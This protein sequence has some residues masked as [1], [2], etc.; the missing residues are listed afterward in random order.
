VLGFVLGSRAARDAQA[1]EQRRAVDREARRAARAAAA[2]A[3]TTAEA[4]KDPGSK[5]G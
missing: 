2:A 3:T 4:A 1:L 5:T